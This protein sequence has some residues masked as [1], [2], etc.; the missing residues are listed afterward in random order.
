MTAR[1]GMSTMIKTVRGM[2][3]AGTADYTIAGENWWSD[4]QIQEA[5]DRNRIDII[6]CGLQPIS[7]YDGAG[8]IIC[9]EY[10]MGWDNIESGTAVFELQDS[11]GN[12]VGTAE[13]SVDYARGIVN[14]TNDRAGS[15]YYW[16]GRSYDLNGAAADIWRL[17]SAQA[18][19]TFTWSTDNM[20]VDKG[21][22]VENSLKMAEY[23]SRL[24]RIS[25]VSI[26]RGDEP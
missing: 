2:T 10:H 13:Y 11:S 3:N 17:K 22:L 5:L 19:N 21:K 24:K 6:R 25:V 7:N 4:D 18:A 26:Y 16:T 9:K 12:S 20:K 1:S 8:N 15:V 23:Y 14:F